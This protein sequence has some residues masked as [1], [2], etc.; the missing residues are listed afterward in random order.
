MSS[1]RNTPNTPM[2]KSTINAKYSFTRVSKS[3]MVSTPVKYTRALSMT[4]TVP[5]PST[6]R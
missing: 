2:T 6:P 3:H 5:N 1:D 4:S